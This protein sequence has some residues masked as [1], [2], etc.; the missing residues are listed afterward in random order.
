MTKPKPSPF[1]ADWPGPVYAYIKVAM[2][3]IGSL[4]ILRAGQSVIP[5]DIERREEQQGTEDS[6]ET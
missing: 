3:H 5:V 4:G 6:P 2:T 1:P